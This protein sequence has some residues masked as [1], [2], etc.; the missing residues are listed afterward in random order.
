MYLPAYTL[1]RQCLQAHK[2]TDSVTIRR[3]VFCPL[4]ELMAVA[5]GFDEKWYSSAYDDVARARDSGR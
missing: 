3:A 5:S 1:M 4:L 2:D